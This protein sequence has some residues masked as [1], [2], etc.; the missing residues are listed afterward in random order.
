MFSN[1]RA[2]TSFLTTFS[3]PNVA[4]AMSVISFIILPLWFDIP[5]MGVAS[6]DVRQRV[7]YLHPDSI[8]Q[9]PSRDFSLL[10]R[11]LPCAPHTPKTPGRKYPAPL[12][13]V[14]LYE[15]LSVTRVS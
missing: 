11:P 10:R 2:F 5:G 8:S 7:L 6:P 9:T 12:F 15:R 1:P 14:P 13:P 3:R 4:V